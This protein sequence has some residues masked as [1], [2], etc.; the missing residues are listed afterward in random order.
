MPA[1]DGGDGFAVVG[2]LE[3]FLIGVVVIEDAVDGDRK[4]ETERKTPCLS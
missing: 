1:F 3:R 2:V 4:V